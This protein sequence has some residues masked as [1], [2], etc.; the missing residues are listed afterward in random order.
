MDFPVINL[1]SVIPASAAVN[2]NSLVLY[3]DSSYTADVCCVF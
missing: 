1:F 3:R 2:I